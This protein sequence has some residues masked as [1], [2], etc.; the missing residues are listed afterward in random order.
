MISKSGI[1]KLALGITSL[2]SSTIS[3]MHL[4]ASS[5]GIFVYKCLKSIIK[6]KQCLLNLLFSN[7]NIPHFYIIWKILK[8]PIVG[9]PIVAGYNWILT[10]VSIFV[11]HY[12]KE[13][14]IKFNSILTD[15]LSLIKMLET[16]RFNQKC[17]LFTIDF[18]S[19]YTNI[20]VEDA[21]KCIK[22]LVEEY[23]DVIPNT[24]FIIEL[25]EII[26]KNSLM[27]FNGEY[28]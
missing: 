23:H 3:L 16:S 14:Y 9:R 17:C 5:T 12:L 11:G 18:K 4:I 2:Y 13:F 21:I 28:F 7:F 25:L 15:S 26:L 1:I 27:T 19:L 24:N 22:E 10:L 8:N 6:T 20:P